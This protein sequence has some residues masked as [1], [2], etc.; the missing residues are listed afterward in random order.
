MKFGHFDDDK[1]EYVIETPATPY[2]WINYLGNTDFY[3]I[4]SHTAGG[5]SFYRDALLRRLTR[6]RYNNV[7]LDNTGRLFY[8]R[9]GETLWSPAWKPAKTPLDA[10]ECRHGLGYTRIKGA[11]NGVTAEVCF[12][13]P[14]ETNAEV[15]VLRLKNDAVQAKKLSVFA[16]VEFCLWNALDDMTNFQRNYSLAEMEI[17]PGVIYHKTEYRER[18]NHYSFYAASLPHQGFD[19]DR[20]SFLGPD[21]NYDR[22]AAVTENKPRNSVAD[23]WSPIACH[24]YEIT[25]APGEE[26]TVIFVLGYVENPEAEKWEKEGIINKKSARALIKRLTVPRAVEEAL[27]ALS[28]HWDTLLGNFC[29]K[30]GS[31]ELNRMVNIWNQYQNVITF[32]ISRSASY[33]ES[34]IGRGVGFRDTNQDILGC[35]HQIPDR[36][37]QRLLDV[38]ATQLESGGAYHQYQPLTKR[39]NSAVG[40]NFNDDPLWLILAV[41][42]YLK[43]T[44]DWSILAE[45]VDFENDARLAAPLFEHLRRAFHHVVDRKGPHGLPLIGRADWNDCLNLNCFSATPDESFQ[46]CTTKDGKTAE[47]VLIAGMF[48]QIGADYVEIAR[49][50]GFTDEAAWAEK[51]IAVMEKAVLDHGWDG[52]WYLRAYDDAG[53]KVGSRECEDGK[54]FIE[55]QGY[56]AWAGIGQD[57]G[58]PDKALAAV[59]KHLGTK[60]GIVLVWPAYKRYHLELGEVSTYVPGYKENGGVFCHNNPWIMIAD[61][62][63][64]HAN[65][66]WK[67]YKSITPAF[68]ENISE[69]HRL[70][71]YVYAQMI[72][73]KEAGRHGEAK[74]SWLTGTASWNFVAVSQWILGI[75]PGFDGL[76]IDPKLPDEVPEITVERTFRGAFYI[77][78]VKKQ[79]KEAVR[80]VSAVC[81]G[82]SLNLLHD[83]TVLAPMSRSESGQAVYHNIEIILGKA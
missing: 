19:T 34:G 53:A 27:A 8:I 10:Y 57:K 18:R 25:L 83:G 43:E 59:E 2:P 73:G 50:S 70:E 26:K 47:S 40:G 49:R 69:V 54:I 31:A 3:S 37:R 14:L 33:F 22:P 48:V 16:A 58:Y 82:Q 55:S 12:F 15:Q 41:A 61:S 20:D 63:N 39:G 7:P 42:A 6:Y 66:A 4:I 9:D 30:S 75:R 44:G 71:P 45:K 74:N 11:K 52:D 13:V 28:R 80:I 51:E 23:G 5:Y 60:H 35:T 1:R 65:R 24:Q 77:I 68:R 21:N 46:T 17:E 81:D 38:A 72:A 32:N 78:H 67:Y 56:C 62:M 79:S 29:L 64:G 76:V 36:V